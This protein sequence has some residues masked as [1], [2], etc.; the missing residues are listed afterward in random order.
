MAWDVHIH[1]CF[2]C[3]DNDPVAALAQKH[4]DLL[5]VGNLDLGDSN[6]EA[7]WFLESLSTR[8]G[9][10]H[11]TKGGLSLWGMIGNYVDGDDFVEVLKPFWS[12]LLSGKHG[13]L[14]FEHV[15]VFTEQEQDGYAVS[16]EIRNDQGNIVVSKCDRL[17]FCWNQY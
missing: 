1:V 15:V 2:S 7:H 10:N 16:Y 17:P 8:T 13:P 14:D 3:V 11:G 6:R 9:E 12:D 5:P 4:L